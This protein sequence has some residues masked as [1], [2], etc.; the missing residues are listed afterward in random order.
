[1]SNVAMGKF[2]S[3]ASEFMNYWLPMIIATGTTEETKNIAYMMVFK[4]RK[5]YL[6][7]EEAELVSRKELNEILSSVSR[8]QDLMLKVTQIMESLKNFHYYPPPE[9][10]PH[11]E[12]EW[13]INLLM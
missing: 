10:Y 12:K 1:M 4:Y 7:K 8:I 6:T 11:W 5:A 2:N 9:Y 3:G 13:K